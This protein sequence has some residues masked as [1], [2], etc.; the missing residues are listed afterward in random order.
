MDKHFCYKTE[1]RVCASEIRFDL[2]DGVIQNT[3]FI[4]GC[5]GNTTGV[6]NLVEGMKAEDVVSKLK[7]VDCR[8]GNSCPNELATAIERCLQESN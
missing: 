7:G 8:N 2:V 4:G 3:K 1:G 5:R 6:A